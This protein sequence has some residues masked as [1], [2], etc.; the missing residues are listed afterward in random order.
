M[1][2]DTDSSPRWA[3]GAL[4]LVAT[5]VLVF[6]GSMAAT[7]RDLDEQVTGGSFGAGMGLFALALS[8]EAAR[9]SRSAWLALWYLPLFLASHVIWLGVWVPDLPLLVLTAAALIALRP[10]RRARSA[11]AGAGSRFPAASTAT[12]K[13]S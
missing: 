4:L 2:R 1:T 9:G 8:L 12:V 13:N 5:L 3:L 7:G 6:G 10:Q 11:A